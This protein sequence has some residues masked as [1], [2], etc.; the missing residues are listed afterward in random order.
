MRLSESKRPK[1]DPLQSAICLQVKDDRKLG[2]SVKI[3]KEKV[4]VESVFL[5][6]LRTSSFLARHEV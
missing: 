6:S 2:L 1:Q 4:Y 5:V 3:L